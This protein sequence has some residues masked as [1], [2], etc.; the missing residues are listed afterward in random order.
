MDEGA[1]GTDGGE[2]TR[3]LWRT[4]RGRDESRPYGSTFHRSGASLRPNGLYTGVGWKTGHD[5]C[6]APYRPKRPAWGASL[7]ERERPA[8]KSAG[9]MPVCAPSLTNSLRPRL[10]RCLHVA[11]T[12]PQCGSE[13]KRCFASHWGG[14]RHQRPKL[15]FGF[16]PPSFGRPCGGRVPPRSRQP[17]SAS[18][19][20]A[21]V[22]A[23]CPRA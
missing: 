12:S 3:W 17:G 9:K 5:K 23:R 22:R 1:S 2:K 18:V 15:R 4:R 13:A 11:S 19:P 20:L 8:R 7:W 6:P 10:R 14:F 16:P 21:S